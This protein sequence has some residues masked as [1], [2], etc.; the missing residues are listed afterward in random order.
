M[1]R[2]V[3]YFSLG[4]FYVDIQKKKDD[5]GF[6]Q[7]MIKDYFV[8]YEIVS[9]VPPTYTEK[10]ELATG[11]VDD[12]YNIICYSTRPDVFVLVSD[13]SEFVKFYDSMWDILLK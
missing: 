2:I 12:S 11:T 6:M 5:M 1:E 13:N 10:F 3:M 4:D 9:T 8:D 7:H